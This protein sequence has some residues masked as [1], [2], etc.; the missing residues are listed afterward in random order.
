MSTSFL[1]FLRLWFLITAWFSRDS[2][3]ITGYMRRIHCV[4]A[5][6]AWR[7]RH[8]LATSSRST[9]GGGTQGC[10]PSS[11]ELIVRPPGERTSVMTSGNTSFATNGCKT[12]PSPLPPL[13][14]AFSNSHSGSRS[15]DPDL[16]PAHTVKLSGEF[17]TPGLRRL[18]QTY[19]HV[20]R[21]GLAS[22]T[23]EHRRTHIN[24]AAEGVTSVPQKFI[25][26]LRPVTP[27]PLPP[28]I[29][30]VFLHDLIVPLPA[31]D[32][33]P[34]LYNARLIVK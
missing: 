13:L 17:H 20:S 30:F 16:Q 6:S 31:S 24:L 1:C 33:L 9:W 8:Q 23:V 32:M 11:A 10:V 18:I 2:A 34:A 22:P 29:N 4:L 14:S 5:R 7:E 19:A 21:E 3:Q 26:I 12:L 27:L 28:R 15:L 25:P